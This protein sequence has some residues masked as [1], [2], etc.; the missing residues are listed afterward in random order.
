M[1]LRVARFLPS[2][3]TIVFVACAAAFTA[4]SA[5]GAAQNASAPRFDVTSVKSNRSGQP[6]VGG[7][8]DRFDHGQFQ[9]TNIPLRLLIRQ[10]FERWQDDDTMGGPSW[11]DSDRWDIAAKTESPTADML[12]MIRSLLEDRFQLAWHLETKER[13][14]YELTLAQRGSLSS[15]LR[16]SGGNNP[17]Y[18]LGSTGQITGRAV[19]LQQLSELLGSAVRRKVVDRTGL[20]GVYDVDLRWSPGLSPAVAA[21]DQPDIFTAVREQLGLQLKSSRGP[22]DVMV[23]ERAERPTP[24]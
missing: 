6:H 12:P 8:G 19:T 13:P 3:K 10:A 4:A 7:A 9:T 2:R 11:L 22:V 16:A 24:D 1:R 5:N 17:P 14:I 20:T 21:S 23:I 18:S 15:S